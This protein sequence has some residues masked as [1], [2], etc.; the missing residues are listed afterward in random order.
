MIELEIKDYQDY[1]NKVELEIK[2]KH[3]ISGDDAKVIQDAVNTIVDT[4]RKYYAAEKA[5]TD[6][7]K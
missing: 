7:K 5:K 2:T 1:D 3:N 4:A 6:A